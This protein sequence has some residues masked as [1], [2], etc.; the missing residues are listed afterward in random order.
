MSNRT[1]AIIKP[2]AIQN[3]LTG[4][5]IDHILDNGFDIIAMK[6]IHLSVAEAKEFYAIHKEKPFYSDLV[7]F[8]TSG[9]C[10]VLTLQKEE[11]VEAW[12]N[13]IGATDPAEASPGTIRNLYADT[14]QN[15]AVHGSDSDENAIKEI[16]FFFSIN[17]ILMN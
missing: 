1:L 4:K 15:N 9:P 8:M 6:K 14:V 5:I 3:R 11:A 7:S 2:D 13:T 17:E 16:A 12:R 10:V